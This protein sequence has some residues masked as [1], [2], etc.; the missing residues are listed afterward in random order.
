MNNGQVLNF[1]KP[2]VEMVSE[3]YFK[4]DSKWEIPKEL[5]HACKRNLRE[6]AKLQKEFSDLQMDIQDV[7][8][9][10][11]GIGDVNEDNLKEINLLYSKFRSNPENIK[12]EIDF[13]NETYKPEFFKVSKEV[14]DEAVIPVEHY[15]V[16]ENLMLKEDEPSNPEG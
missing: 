3:E 13:L 14:A 10:E 16:I 6:I 11:N 8:K 4:S 5:F 9:K 12:A 7:F 1:I 15:F 2:L